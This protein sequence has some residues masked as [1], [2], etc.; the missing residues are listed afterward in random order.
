MS[1]KPNTTTLP[2]G[3][4]LFDKYQIRHTDGTPLKGKRYFVLRLDADDPKPK[5]RCT[6]GLKTDEERGV[7]VTHRT[8]ADGTRVETRGRCPG[9]VGA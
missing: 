6:R 3:W 2:D 7:P 8:R 5:R 4:R 9:G 1:D